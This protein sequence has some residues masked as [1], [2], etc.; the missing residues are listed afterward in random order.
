MD[1][2]S[3]ALGPSDTRH[4]PNS[5][6]DGAGLDERET[7]AQLASFGM[8]QAALEAAVIDIQSLMRG[9][10]ARMKFAERLAVQTN[11]SGHELT[12][13]EPSEADEEF[14]DAEEDPQFVDMDVDEPVLSP[15]DQFWS[16]LESIAQVNGL[17]VDKTPTIRGGGTIN[18]WQL[19]SI[20][21]QQNCEPEE[22]DWKLVTEGLG[23]EPIK[24][25]ILDVQGCY[26]QNLDEYESF[27]KALEEEEGGA[28]EEIVGQGREEEEEEAVEEM[29]E[30]GRRAHSPLQTSDAVTAPKQP[31]IVPSSPVI[32]S[33]PP[34]AANKRSF[35]QTDP[36]RSDPSYPSTGPRKRR[37]VDRGSVIPATPEHKLGLFSQSHGHPTRNNDSSPLKQQSIAI[38]ESIEISSGDES[39]GL[40]SLSDLPRKKLVEPETQDWHIGQNQLPKKKIVEP[41]TQD[42]HTEQDYVYS[43]DEDEISPS[44]QLRLESD[45]LRGPSSSA[46][47]PRGSPA[48]NGMAMAMRSISRPPAAPAPVARSSHAPFVNATATKRTLPAQ[49]NRKPAVAAPV[50]PPIPKLRGLPQPPTRS[51][52]ASAPRISSTAPVL[53]ATNTVGLSSTARFPSTAPARAATTKAPRPTKADTRYDDVWVD[54]EIRYFQSIGYDADD[55]AR[56]LFA[57]NCQRTPMVEAI[58]SLHKRQGLPQTKRGVW[59]DQDDLDLNMIKKHE[60]GFVEGKATADPVQARRVTVNA[61]LLEEKHG[62]TGMETRWAFLTSDQ[63]RT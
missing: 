19:Y 59:T 23:L 6:L 54:A 7:E 10:G 29:V 18:L 51:N 61:W 42:W 52:G 25:V 48:Q 22:R 45:G 46:I 32:G 14:Q 53:A 27:I 16:D 8:D 2:A 4:H 38:G 24:Y 30:Q 3:P 15:E 11:E 9:Y 63:R 12:E 21:T 36:F 20:A 37:R 13:A 49:Y 35:G 28:G 17:A 55:A 58:E 60:L 47:D 41:E 57:T 1:P 44:Q 50:P 33:S 5:N 26:L 40:P 62:K 31:V 43:E 34:P 39:D 56:A